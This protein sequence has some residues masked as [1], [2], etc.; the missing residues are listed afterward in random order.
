MIIKKY[1]VL[2]TNS[3]V[4]KEGIKTLLSF[5]NDNQVVIPFPILDEL[6][7]VAKEYNQKGRNA[8]AILDY[9]SSFKIAELLSANGVMQKNGSSLRLAKGFEG[10]DIP[11][12]G[13]SAI[14]KNCLQIAKGLQEESHGKP[15]ILVSKNAALRIKANS[16]GIKAQ[17]F[18]DDIFPALNEQYTGRVECKTSSAKLGH[19]MENGFMPVKA[20]SDHQSI[21]WMPNLFL[22]ITSYTEPSKTVIARYD[23]QKIVKLNHENYHPYQI[24]VMNSGQTMILEALMESAETAPIVII[25]GGAGTGKTYASLAVALDQTFTGDNAKYSQIM[26]TT[27]VET[28]G[29]E[30]I[31]F[32]PGD[33][34]E[35]FNPHLGGVKDNL[36]ILSSVNGKKKKAGQLDLS[37]YL[38]SGKIQVQPIGFLRGRTIVDTFFIIDETQ[39]IAPD[40]IKSI[41][42][43]AGKGSKFVFLGDPTQIDNPQLNERY[44][45]LVYLSE[46]MKESP[47]AW[48]V[49]LNDTE[50]VRS[51]LARIAT[52]I[53]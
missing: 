23:G 5:D 34:E 13:L 20:I 31:G 46:K 19:F 43:R 11:L 12:S 49:T 2:R 15:V 6:E 30:Q 14:D 40:D 22:S 51:E 48:Q 47:L 36:R 41:V 1:F 52:Q 53:L 18:R 33:I 45:G 39:N 8:K 29:Q 25:K 21:E 3:L 26:V 10:V 24:N 37:T 50:S 35:K 4:A 32:L 16:I 27:P 28:V 38:N 9:L 44:N 7:K 42:S 17:N